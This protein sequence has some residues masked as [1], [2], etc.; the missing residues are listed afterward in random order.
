MTRL[1][2]TQP[3]QVWT[4]DVT[5][6]TGPTKGEHDKLSVVLDLY[7]RYVVA[8]MRARRESAALARRLIATACRRHGMVPGQLTT[9]RDRGRLH[10]AKDLHAPY[11]D[12]GLVRSRSRPRVNNDH[13]HVESLFKTTTYSAGYPDRF[14]DFAHAE[15]WCAAF[16][17]Y[18][19][20][21]HTHSWIA[22]CTPAMVYGGDAPA[23]LAQRHR[24]MTRA[25]ALTPARFVRGAPRTATLPTTVSIHPIA[26]DHAAAINTP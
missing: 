16:F 15:Q 22:S 24:T 21:M 2:A 7:R 13:P 11:E 18:D 9:H 3:N 17:T 10:L 6:L 20:T 23:V 5:D 12:L 25:F 1:T 19:N 14:T 4:W 8:W 26:E